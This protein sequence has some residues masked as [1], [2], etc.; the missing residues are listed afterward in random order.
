MHGAS[1]LKLLL[2]SICLRKHTLHM[3]LHSIPRIVQS[4]YFY[5]VYSEENFLKTT[6]LFWEW[7][8]TESSRVLSRAIGKIKLFIH[9]CQRQE[10]PCPGHQWSIG[11]VKPDMGGGCL[12]RLHLPAWLRLDMGNRR[13][14]LSD[15]SGRVSQLKLGGRHWDTHSTGNDNQANKQ[16][17]GQIPRRKERFTNF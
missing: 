16:T 7:V 6:S 2:L 12:G 9:W 5:M 15:F 1:K 10:L 14:S 13:K 17:D 11:E 3:G 8:S 4:R